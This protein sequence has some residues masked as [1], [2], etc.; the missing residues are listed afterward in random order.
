MG[1]LLRTELAADKALRRADLGLIDGNEVGQGEY[2]L[3]F[4]GTDRKEMWRV[5]EPIFEEAP[6]EW[7][8][9]ELRNGIDD[10]FPTT[11]PDG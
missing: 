6:V 1:S 10:K 4:V 3:N 7:V 11:L 9:V 8:R 5:L 2:D